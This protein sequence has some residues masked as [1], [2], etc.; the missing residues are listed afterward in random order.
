MG[1]IVWRVNKIKILITEKTIIEVSN[2]ITFLV[3][4]KLL[5]R[6]PFAQ[7]KS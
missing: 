6:L 7:Q 5:E 1:R 2:F 4:L 3:F